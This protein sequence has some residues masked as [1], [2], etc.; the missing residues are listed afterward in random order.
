M[1]IQYIDPLHRAW[2][3]MKAILFP[4]NLGKWFALGFTAF[5]AHLLDMHGG[6]QGGSHRSG[7]DLNEFFDLPARAQA[8]IAAH[9]WIVALI[10][11]GIIMAFILG[12]VC[13]WL[14]SRGLFMFLDNVVHNRALIQQPWHEFKRRA[15]SLFLWRLL[16]GFFSLV[17]LIEFLTAGFFVARDFYHHIDD[18]S[19]HVFMLL[20]LA[21][22]GFAL[23]VILLAVARL[24]K[25]FVVPIMYR[26]DL[27]VVDAAGKFLTV[28]SEHIGG[29][30]LYMLFLVVLYIVTFVCIAIAGVITLGIGFVILIIPYIASVVLLPVSVLFRAYSVEF[31]EQFG[32][33]FRIFPVAAPAPEV[34]GPASTAEAQ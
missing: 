34:S 28:F 18:V 5:L 17:M 27:S 19:S 10:I 1:D 9:P 30:V 29:F 8:W 22:I 16:L 25:D 14:S 32:E 20:G 13:L 26:D 2:N 31:L 21:F 11:A 23:L 24:L 7:M 15:D 33:D 4:I 12:I 6:G 3:R